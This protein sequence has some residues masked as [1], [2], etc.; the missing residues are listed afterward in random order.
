MLGFKEQEKLLRLIGDTL[1]KPMECYV[2]GGSAMLFYNFSKTATKDIDAITFS[3]ADMKTLLKTLRR[4]GFKTITGSGTRP[5]TP[6]RLQF[7]DYIFDVFCR[8]LFKLRVSKAMK[9]RSRERIEFGKLSVLV[10]SPEDIILSK[11]MTDREGDRRDVCDIIKEINVDWDILFREVEWQSKNNPN[12]AFGV[13]LFD[14]LQEL[15]HNFKADI[16]RDVIRKIT[17]L[18]EKK[19]DELSEQR[20]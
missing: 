16:P 6:A 10:A 14:F 2:V 20:R 5:G 8:N 7:Q 17:R 9:E 19:L 3:E 12:I 18:Y 15:S 1:E 11:S 4:I 13:Y